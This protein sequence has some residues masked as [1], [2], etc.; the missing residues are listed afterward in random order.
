MFLASRPLSLSLFL[1]LLYLHAL[2]LHTLSAHTCSGPIECAQDPTAEDCTDV[3]VVSPSLVATKLKMEV[4]TN[5]GPY[6]SLLPRGPP[7]APPS[8]PTL[9][10]T[11]TRPARLLAFSTQCCL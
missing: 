6:V 11:R 3:E 2:S 9:V 5:Y 8:A 4:N 7:A 1:S 10:A